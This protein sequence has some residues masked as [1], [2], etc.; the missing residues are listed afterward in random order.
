MAAGL[1][2]LTL[3]LAASGLDASRE[4]SRAI[5]SL[6]L[7]ALAFAAVA[8]PGR[9]PAR[10]LGLVSSRLG[11]MERAAAV[12]LGLLW[13]VLAPSLFATSMPAALAA[14]HAEIGA[15]WLR[16]ALFIGGGMV[17]S[18]LLPAFCEEIFFRGFLQRA[19]TSRVGPGLAILASSIVFAALHVGAGPIGFAFLTSLLLGILVHVSGSLWESI[20]LHAANNALVF[21]MAAI[22]SA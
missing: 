12:A 2:C 18:V 8:L 21:I 11:W 5:F 22:Q 3:V 13:L 17:G 20:A 7:G 10:D 16:T 1:F 4:L 14:T 6:C 19:L 15:G 9:V